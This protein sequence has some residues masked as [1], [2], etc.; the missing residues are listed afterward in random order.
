[1]I[2]TTLTS[3]ID[4]CEFLPGAASIVMASMLLRQDEED[5]TL[6]TS[7]GPASLRL[8]PRSRT[9][10]TMSSLMS[11]LCNSIRSI[12]GDCRR[13]RQIRQSRFHPG[14]ITH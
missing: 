9:I 3:V 10:S 6:K 5:R 11:G 2:E 8:S 12:C 1:M 14:G 7:S 13:S 4:H